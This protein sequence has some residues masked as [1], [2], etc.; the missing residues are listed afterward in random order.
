MGTAGA[1]RPRPRTAPSRCHGPRA[2]ASGTRAN[3]KPG[4]AHG[5][6]QWALCHRGWVMTRR[7]AV[8]MQ[9][10]APGGPGPWTS[11]CWDCWVLTTSE[12]PPRKESKH[13]AGEPECQTRAVGIRTRRRVR[14]RS[15]PLAASICVAR[16]A[17]LAQV[18]STLPLTRATTSFAHRHPSAR[19]Y[20]IG[21][22]VGLVLWASAVA[23]GTCVASPC[24]LSMAAAECGAGS[25]R[26]R[27]AT[28]RRPLQPHTQIAA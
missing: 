27:G 12:S 15:G 26:G 22:Q 6:S 3:L 1:P 11:P 20:P 18:N 4:P 17:A 28:V 19:V 2:T 8:G 5:R 16:S 7:P 10:G 21:G 14:F 25:I 13:G 9:A 24:G 23:L